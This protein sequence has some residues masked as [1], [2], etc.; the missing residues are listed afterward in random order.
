MC[1]LHKYKKEND[2]STDA[3]E[4]GDR[5]TLPYDSTTFSLV[6]I[7]VSIN[8]IYTWLSLLEENLRG[9]VVPIKRR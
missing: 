6:S 4:F 1:G 5:R 2:K 3:T 9:V 8:L 7:C